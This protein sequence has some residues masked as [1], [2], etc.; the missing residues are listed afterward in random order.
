MSKVPHTKGWSL[1][2]RLVFIALV[3]IALTANF[4]WRDIR[5]AEDTVDGAE[6]LSQLVTLER[7]AT[8][9]VTPAYIEQIAQ[10]G[11]ATID[12]FGVERDIVIQFAG[13]DYDALYSANRIE[14]DAALDQLIASNGAIVLPSGATLGGEIE[15]L[16][17]AL[18]ASRL[19]TDQRVGDPVQVKA[20]LDELDGVIQSAIGLMREQLDSS[21]I[22]SG[23]E[24][25]RAQSSGLT[26]VLDTA[27]DRARA[28]LD[29]AI[30]RAIDPTAVA[31][32]SAAH[33]QEAHHFGEI[34]SGKLAAEFVA[35]IDS[36]PEPH[37]SALRPIA[38]GAG[39]LDPTIVQEAAQA[40]LAEIDYVRW[41]GTFAG[42][43]YGDVAAT[44]ATASTDA[45]ASLRST[46][47]V[48]AATVAAS[49][50]LVVLMTGAVLRPIN[51]LRRQAEAI[52]SGNVDLAPLPMSGPSDLRTLSLAMN[53]MVETLSG[54]G[55]QAEALAAGR[56]DDESLA[57]EAPGT[58]GESIRTSVARLTDVTAQLQA[59]E[60]RASAIVSHAAV[61]IWTIDPTGLVVTANTAAEQILQ[62]PEHRQVGRILMLVLGT[63]RGEV[64]VQR[65]DGSRVG[66]LVDNTEVETSNG[67][68]RTVIARDI[69]ERREYERRLAHQA[70]HDALTGLPNR[71]AVL[72]RL[73]LLIDADRPG[74]VLFIDVDGFKSVN[75]SQGHA[76]GDLVLIDV[77]KRLQQELGSG[78]LVARLGGDEFVV[79]V[80]KM[81][82]GDAAVR[83]GR[84]LIERIEQPYQ[85][86]E[87]LFVV[88]ASVGVSVSRPGDEAL[89]VIHRAD[90]AV[91]LAKQRGRGRVEVFDEELQ[92]AIE[93]RA[94]MEFALREAINAEQLS[95]YLQP[96]FDLHT[97]RVCGAEAL[98]RWFR[99]GVGLVPPNEF[100]PVAERSTL[101][102]DIERWMLG[103]ACARIAAWR[104]WD[105]SCRLRIAVNLSGRH[106][107]DGD[108]VEDVQAAIDAAGADPSML[109]LELT[110]SQLLA[111]LDRACEVLEVIRSMGV[112]VAVDDFG[113]GFSSMAYLR[114]LPVDVIK[115]DRSFVSRADQ[116]GFDSSVVEAMV[117]FGRVLNVE[118]VAEG[119]ETESQLDFVRVSGCSRAQGFLLGRPLPADE[120]EALIGAG[121]RIGPDGRTIDLDVGA[122]DDQFTVPGSV[123]PRVA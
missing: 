113:T 91:Y 59:S 60:A 108:V 47:V 31:D 92:A 42:E 61:A 118:V 43:Y 48:L 32:A 121:L 17:T 65:H 116:D 80:E 18:D 29:Y 51:R 107:I 40:L 30:D 33:D 78:G 26:V 46:I 58:L 24:R 86:D 103:E 123:Q 55:R 70:R 72:E 14:L 85:I 115:V 13:V 5:D 87:H 38:P 66:L 119:V 104:R 23:L 2:A 16:R 11:L 111:D 100:I 21:A 56:F 36:H 35:G 45:R 44:A 106:L 62:E 68:L 69:T 93:R 28:V 9:V 99:P 8:A 74:T 6:R 27:G 15:R 112:T 97:G 50:A 90:S 79:V 12:S 53:E 34:L 110:E 73:D 54:I 84:Q 57:T 7:D 88:S 120:T 63:L 75:D 77:A 52:S 117:N 105:P 64:E 37:L 102:L 83:L 96:I 122:S 25:F 19:A 3:P 95:M 22:P 49:L 114:Q 98:A 94:D 89:D 109:E 4:A 10:R 82:G 101:I 71:F 76:I 39:A 67:T 20:I 81:A 41:L 1:A